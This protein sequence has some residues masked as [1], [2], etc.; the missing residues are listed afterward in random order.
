MAPAALTARRARALPRPSL[1]AVGRYL[2]RP[3]SQ[4]FAFSVATMS[5]LAFFPFMI[6][7]IMFIRRVIESRIMCDVLLQTLRPYSHR[8]G[9]RHQRSQ[10]PGECAQESRDQLADC[11][12][13]RCSRRLY[14]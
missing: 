11:F 4:T 1:F 10:R 13:S 7:L 3:Q 8:P 9:V 12:V 2:M 5:V 6:V 14:A